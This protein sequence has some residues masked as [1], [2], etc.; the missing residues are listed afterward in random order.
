MADENEIEIDKPLEQDVQTPPASEQSDDLG[1]KGKAALDAERKARRE[2]EK[3][4]KEGEAAIARLAEIEESAKSEQQK[5]VDRAERAERE[6]AELRLAVLRRDVAAAKG[7]PSE[8][9]ERLSG[10]DRESLEADAD[11]LM[12]VV[13]SQKKPGPP[14][15]PSGGDGPPKAKS[16][17]EAVSARY[18]R[19]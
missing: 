14:N 18:G 5:A 11:A 12:A 2:A 1:D 9:A 6:A 3:R 10:S 15:P 16:L 17:A 8:L 13:A 19:N 7:L 4:A